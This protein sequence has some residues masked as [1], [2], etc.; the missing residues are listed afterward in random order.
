MRTDPILK[1]SDVSYYY[2]ADKRTPPAFHDI[3]LTIDR[4][5]F[6]SIIGPSGAGKSTLLRVLTGLLPASRG[7]VE[8]KYDHL[9]MIFQGHGIFPWETALGNAAFGL[10]MKGVKKKIAERVAKEKLAEVGLAG[11]EKHY[12][13]ELSGGQEQ[14]VAVA[15]AL[16]I[17]P[18]LL[19]MDE[20]FSSL[21]SITASKLKNDIAA[22]WAKY[23]MSILMVSH[24]VGDAVELSDRIVVLSKQPG[25]IKHITNITLPRPRDMR[26]NEA[27]ELTDRLTGMIEG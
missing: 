3:N 15:R 24:I 27:Y 17:T 18:D 8:R 4:G 26:S 11:F 6:I 23:K 16:A 13:H 12:P 1:L 21:D 22:L 25:E 7:E 14:R 5:E 20:P 2:P 19:I 9:A 10:R